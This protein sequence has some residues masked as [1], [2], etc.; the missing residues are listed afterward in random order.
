MAERGM[1]YVVNQSQGF[2]H[3]HVEAELGGN[4]AGDLRHFERVRQSIAKV[5]RIAA[6][7]D[8]G[9]SLEAAKGAGMNDAVA[10][11]LK[12][13]AVGMLRLGETASAG[14]GRMHRVVGEHRKV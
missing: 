6:S 12:V 3:V 7:E 4:G 2:D 14:L 1:A 9:L 13:V 8:L 5:V 10:V 11:A